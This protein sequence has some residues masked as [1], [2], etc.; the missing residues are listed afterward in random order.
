M[1]VCVCVCARV[2]VNVCVCA[3]VAARTCVHVFSIV[4]LLNKTGRVDVT[5]I[6]RRDCVT[7]KLFIFRSQRRTFLFP[8]RSNGTRDEMS[9]VVGG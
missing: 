1:S 6:S 5:R 3:S 2:C 4:L 7:L 8:Y 9:R